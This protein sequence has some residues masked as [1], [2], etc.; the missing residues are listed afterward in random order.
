MRKVLATPR[1]G[2]HAKQLELSYFADEK[3]K[4]CSL[5]R[6]LIEKRPKWSML[7]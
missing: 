6:M 3:A 5:S 7:Q 2:K 1:A 4:Y